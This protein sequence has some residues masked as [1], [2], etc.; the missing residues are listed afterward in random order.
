MVLRSLI[1]VARLTYFG[2]LFQIGDSAGI[3]VTDGC[4]IQIHKDMGLVA[5]VFNEENINKLKGY[6]Y[7]HVRYS[8]NRASLALNAQPL[9]CLFYKAVA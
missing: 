8:Y 5:E 2:R 1:D 9:V 3:V 7:S 6:S 4:G